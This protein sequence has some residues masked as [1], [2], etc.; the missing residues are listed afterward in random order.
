MNPYTILELQPGADET[1][2]RKAY[3]RLSMRY[4][5][6]RPEGNTVKFQELKAAR[7]ALLPP[8]PKGFGQSVSTQGTKQGFG[9]SE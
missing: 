8:A 7:D 9:G 2:V 4:H 6:D 5:P 1:Q 3:R